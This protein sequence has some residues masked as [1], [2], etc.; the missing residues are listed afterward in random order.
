MT[1]PSLRPSRR[2]KL[3]RVPQNRATTVFREFVQQLEKLDPR[4][5][6]L[7]REASR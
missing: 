7:I 1:R 4:P 2:P 3:Q 6:K 5:R